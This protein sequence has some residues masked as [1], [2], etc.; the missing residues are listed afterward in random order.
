MEDKEALNSHAQL[1]RLLFLCAVCSNSVGTRLPGGAWNQVK[2]RAAWKHGYGEPR[3]LAM[4]L[5]GACRE[6]GKARLRSLGRSLSWRR[7]GMN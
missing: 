7:L 2:A 3:S 4:R 5:G 6:W 1:K